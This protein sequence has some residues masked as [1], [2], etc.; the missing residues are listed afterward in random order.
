MTHLFLRIWNN[1]VLFEHAWKG[2][3]VQFEDHNKIVHHQVVK[4]IYLGEQSL[5][6]AFDSVKLTEWLFGH[7]VELLL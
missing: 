6:T 2:L 3:F 5:V 4:E 7:V 1:T